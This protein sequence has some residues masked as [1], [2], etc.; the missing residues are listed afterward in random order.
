MKSRC[1]LPLFSRG[2][3]ANFTKLKKS[4][5][6]DNVLIE[7]NLAL[8][9]RERGLIEFIF[10]VLIGDMIEDIEDIKHV[11]SYSRYFTSGCH[12]DLSANGTICVDSIVAKLMEHLD[13]LSLGSLLL[14]KLSIQEIVAK[15]TIN[16]GFQISG[17][18]EAA[19]QQLTAEV[20]KMIRS[21]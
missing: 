7:Y 19:F 8:E 6:C 3:S 14:E 16:Q 2:S 21:N 1:F 9:L 4:S 15:I 13:R 20:L 10:P 5:H 18:G 11:K 12:P 17:N